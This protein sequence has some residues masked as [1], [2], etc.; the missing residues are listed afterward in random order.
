MKSSSRVKG[1][2]LVELLVVIGVITVLISLL[3]PALGRARDQAMRVTCANQL[4]Q[5]VLAMN[6]YASAD[7][8][9]SYPRTKFDPERDK[10]LLNNAGYG[11]EETFGHS[12]Y[13]GENNV[14]AS[15]YL[16]MR[17]Q[18]LDPKLF[19]CPNSNGAVGKLKDGIEANSNWD[20]IPEQLTYSI[21]S[22]YPSPAAQAEGFRWGTATKSA[23]AIIGDMNPGTRGGSRP[24]NNSA[25]PKHNAPQSQMRAANSNNHGN[26]GQNVAFNDGHV[27]FSDTPYC[28]AVHPTTGIPDNI[29]TAGTGDNGTTDEKSLPVDRHDSV[30]LPTDDPGGK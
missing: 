12:G 4:R 16:L 25:G 19:I 27:I 10:M 2:T 6:A 20:E 8:H 15:L 28:G 11:V 5:L 24:P 13:V 9:H 26:R 23:F 29:Y 1:F 30:L 14:P 17:S 7:Q 3:L 21:A 22:A 18:R